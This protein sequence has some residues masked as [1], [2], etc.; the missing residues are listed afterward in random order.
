MMI[1]F[2]QL[3]LYHQNIHRHTAV[4]SQSDAYNESATYAST[5]YFRYTQL[6]DTSKTPTIR[7]Y[8]PPS[9]S[10]STIT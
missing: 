7:T 9:P 8:V 10:S 3:K 6:L 2:K 5:F 4:I 1:L